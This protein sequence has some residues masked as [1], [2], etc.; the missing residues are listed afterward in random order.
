VS[1]RLA[2]ATLGG[3]L[4]LPACGSQSRRVAYDLA[5][6]AAVAERWSATEVV[7]FGDRE[8]DPRVREGVAEEVVDGRYGPFRAVARQ[9][10]LVF[11]W[12]A[13][14][15]RVAIL[16]AEPWAGLHGQSI[17]VRLNGMVVGRLRMSDG[18][19][20]YL[21]P[22]PAGAQR[23]GAN[24]VRLDFEAAVLERGAARAA[25]LYGFVVGDA[26][27][28]SLLDLL[29]RAAPSPFSVAAGEGRPS[30]GLVGPALVRFALRLPEAAQLRF[31]PELA[32]SARPAGGR[33]S[34]RVL[35]EREGGGERE[36]WSRVVGARDPDPGEQVVPLEGA[37]GDVVRVTLAVGTAGSPRFAWG[38]FVAP[39]VVGRGEADPL[40]PQPLPARE[41]ERAA[42][43]RR[44]LKGA[45]VV[46]VILDAAR[47]SQFG[48]Y[49]YDRRTT[50]EIDRIAAEGVVFER[51]Y[52][53]AAFTLAAMASVW[54]SQ[55]PDENGAAAS[56]E[57]PLPED[58]L[59]LAELLSPRGIHTAG[60]IANGMAGTAFG[61]DR[62]FDEFH[63]VFRELGEQADAFRKVL[64]PWLAA[65]R[66]RR[67]FAYVHFREPHF[68]YDPPP[69]WD[70]RFGPEGPI[71][72]EVRRDWSLFRQYNQGTRAFGEAERAHVVSL[73]DGNLGFVDQE[74]GAFRV[75]LEEQGLWDG[76]VFIV[77]AD[78][79][80]A[81][82]ER[83]YTGHNVEVYETTAHVPLVVHLPASAGLKPRRV[84]ALVDLLDVAPT[85]ADVFGSLGEGRSA[86]EFRGRSLLPVLLG[87]PGKPA[88][89][90]RSV[91]ERP[92]YGLRDERYSFVLDTRFGREHLFDLQSDPGE[93]RDL[94]S[95]RP[96]RT[97]CYREA[98]RSWL[99]SVKR[100]RGTPEAG[101][102]LSR[103][104][105]ENLRTLGYISGQC[106]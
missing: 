80:E 83:G 57:D 48:S 2:A 34:F 99:L 37:A 95:E 70:T 39:R 84:S 104:Q 45:N 20:R 41:S 72:R 90:T 94:T 26:G 44:A 47:A 3:L 81:L 68:P 103:E 74:V 71:P 33:A 30:I 91:W 56:F 46:F 15:P 40:R 22:L 7:L 77:A 54:T 31:A 5:A 88:V 59:T 4:A 96:L 98:I 86:E 65:N 93:T 29:D 52:T 32:P 50:P 87:A 53:P 73:Y 78:H 89:L 97:A 92:R 1:R 49:G 67:F 9:G 13:P 19:R 102:K 12:D 25:A 42:A 28:S 55:Y 11:E 35:V 43:L 18:R 51:A 38:R 17:E 105:C 62:G 61:L 85:I 36:V 64:P 106:P 63:E 69:P 75:A 16:D 8:P 101:A 66:G 23:P 82:G 24:R 76:T 6:R 100:G 21:V 14:R 10:R 58:R 60:F 79:G 27:D